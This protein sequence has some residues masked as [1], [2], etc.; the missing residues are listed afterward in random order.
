MEFEK[1]GKTYVDIYL[2]EDWDSPARV[3]R[4]R[5]SDV[6]EY[7]S[8]QARN[9]T[10]GC[11]T[12]AGITGDWRPIDNIAQNCLSYFRQVNVE[13]IRREARKLGLTPKF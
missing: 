6:A 12:I 3:K 5:I 2:S 10:S 13:G 9:M 7:F 4:I 1:G 11:R 8:T